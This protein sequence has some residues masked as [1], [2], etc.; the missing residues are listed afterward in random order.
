[1]E[2]QV[3]VLRTQLSLAVDFQRPVSLHCVGAHG[4]LLKLLQELFP[5]AHAPGLVPGSSFSLLFQC[6]SRFFH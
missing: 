2:L 6:A 1:M 5:E 3:S 4:A